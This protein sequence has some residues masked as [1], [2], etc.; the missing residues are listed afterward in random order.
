MSVK[1]IIKASFDQ[2]PVG[3]T[4]AFN[5]AIKDKLMNALEA[6]RDEIAQSM[7]GSAE[8]DVEADEEELDNSD[9]EDDED[10]NT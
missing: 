6:R 1:D 2:D 3:V 8:D 10:E 9:I 4:G 7:Y 5:S